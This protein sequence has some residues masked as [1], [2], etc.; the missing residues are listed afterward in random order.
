M[1]L[2]LVL[3]KTCLKY[4]V[5]N[6]DCHKTHIFILVFFSKNQFKN[7]IDNYNYFR[8]TFFKLYEKIKIM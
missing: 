4:A 6:K 8:H 2:Q 7:K 3:R 1:C 5:K